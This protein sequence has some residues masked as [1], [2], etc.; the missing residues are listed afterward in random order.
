MS[1]KRADNC[2]L[3]NPCYRKQKKK[4]EKKKNVALNKVPLPRGKAICD[5]SL[6]AASLKLIVRNEWYCAAQSF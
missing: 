4:K 2:Y 1:K 3:T 5:N 6:I